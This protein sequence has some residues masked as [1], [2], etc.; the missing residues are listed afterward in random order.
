MSFHRTILAACTMV[1]ATILTSTAF[2]GCDGCGFGYSAPVAYVEPVAAAPVY[3]GGCG[4]CCGGCGTVAYAQPV[5]VAPPPV[6]VQPAPVMVAPAPIAVG[7]GSWGSCGG[8]GSWGNCGG[9]GN[10]GSWGS[11]GGCGGCGAAL[12]PSAAYVVNQG[13]VYSGPGIMVP[14]GSYSPYAGLSNPAAY[15]YIGRPY[16]YA[17][18]Y[19]Y[20]HHYYHRYHYWRG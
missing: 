7:C 12:V 11:C 4:G 20:R 5:V 16:G 3:A 13:P 18:H 6:L 9:W 14:N 2:A 15:P 1:F 19:A 17:P 10:C 8:C